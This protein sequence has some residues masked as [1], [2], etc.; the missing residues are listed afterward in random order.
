MPSRLYK[1]G[2]GSV[3]GGA[4]AGRAGPREQSQVRWV[5]GPHGRGGS[6]AGR[7]SGRGGA[8]PHGQRCQQPPEN[9]HARW[10]WDGVVGGEA[11][12]RCALRFATIPE[13]L[14]PRDRLNF[15]G[16]GW[17]PAAVPGRW[18]Q[19]GP[20]TALGGGGHRP[21]LRETLR[22][23]CERVRAQSLRSEGSGTTAASEIKLR[24]EAPPGV[25]SRAL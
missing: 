23:G 2:S 6:P 12:A 16:A 3:P 14:L 5:F 19:H 21:W 13:T 8:A 15:S 20:A 18:Q 1:Q 22:R 25:R 11:G 7:T 4:L 17:H 9:G 24:R 10:C